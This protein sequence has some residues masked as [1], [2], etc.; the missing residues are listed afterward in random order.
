MTLHWSSE[1]GLA[2]LEIR[3]RIGRIPSGTFKRRIVVQLPDELPVL[4]QTKVADE[5]LILDSQPLPPAPD[6]LTLIPC[7][8]PPPARAW[9]TVHLPRHLRREAR[10]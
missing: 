5:P 7:C 6:L 10:A 8:T 3:H 9:R 2:P 1:V 4:K